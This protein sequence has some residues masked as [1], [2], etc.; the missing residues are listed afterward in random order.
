MTDLSLIINELT[1]LYM[2]FAGT[3]VAKKTSQREVFIKEILFF[4]TFRSWIV[5][6]GGIVWLF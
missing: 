4:W 2:A 1:M 3:D 5:G 6:W